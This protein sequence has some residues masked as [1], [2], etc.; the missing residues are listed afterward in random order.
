MKLKKVND[1]LYQY[2]DEKRGLHFYLNYGSRGVLSRGNAWFFNLIDNG[3]RIHI[4][5]FTTISDGNRCEKEDYERRIWTLD[6]ILPVAEKLIN[7]FQ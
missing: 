7:R 4:A 2:S 3:C 1:I 6:E 5:T